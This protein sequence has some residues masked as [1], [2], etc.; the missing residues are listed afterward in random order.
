MTAICSY[1]RRILP[2]A[3]IAKFLVLFEYTNV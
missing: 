3:E 2:F 1:N